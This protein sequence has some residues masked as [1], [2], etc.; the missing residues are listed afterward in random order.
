MLH[1]ERGIVAEAEAS[2]TLSSPR[3]G[4][5]EADPAGWWEN[6][7]TTTRRCL[8]DAGVNETSVAGIG[9]SGMVPTLILLDGDGN[10]LRPSIQQNDARTVEEIQHFRQQTNA[11]DILERTGSAITQQSIGPKLLWLRRHE[12]E[13]MDSGRARAGFLRLHRLSDDGQVL[14]RKQL[15][16]RKRALHQG[17]S[18]GIRRCSRSARFLRIGS[19]PSTSLRNSSAS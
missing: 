15:G 9:V 19:V 10:V 3:A 8:A 6:A 16:P 12:P 1:P 2:S 18:S 7:G 13:V 4:W 17:E 5:A 14:L 11:D